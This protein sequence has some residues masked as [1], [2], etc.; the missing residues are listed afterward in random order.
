MTG[1]MSNM[2]Q[3]L[4]K[5]LTFF[6]IMSKTSSTTTY[7]NETTA[8]VL[9]NM[10]SSFPLLKSL[11]TPWNCPPKAD[12]Q[13]NKWCTP[14][15]SGLT[16]DTAKNI[17]AI[18]LSGQ[19]LVGILPNS[20]G[21]LITLKRRLWMYDNHIE[22]PIPNTLGNLTRLTSLRFDDNSLTGNVPDSL[23]RLTLLETLNLNR[24]YLNVTNNVTYYKTNT[25]NDDGSN[26]ESSFNQLTYYPTG[27]PSSQPS[28]QPTSQPSRQPSSQPSRQP[29][30]QPSSQPSEFLSFLFITSLIYCQFISN[31]STQ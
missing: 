23:R 17:I 29:S 16:C 2:L 14:S 9:C 26:T 10:T 27:Q 12:I 6:I 28:R 4:T 22:G 3:I 31:P 24:N 8:I 5:L 19:E 18:D 11:P 21:S 25:F 7:Y 15:W 30:R 1:R 13:I 20:L